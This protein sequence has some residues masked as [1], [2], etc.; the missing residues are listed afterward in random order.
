MALKAL[1]FSLRPAYAAALPLEWT[2]QSCRRHQST[3]RRTRKALRVKPDSSFL[4]TTTEPTDHV[5]FNP[6]SSAPN[7]YHTPMKFL[8]KDDPRQK[9]HTLATATRPPSSIVPTPSSDSPTKTR[10][11]PSVR[12]I[13]QKKYHLT[14][15]E[16]DEIR[17]LREEDP[18]HWTRVRLGEKF[19]CSEFF[20]SLCCKSPEIAAEREKEIEQ[21][22]SRWGRS[23][24][25]AREERVERRKLWGRDA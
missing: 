7:I 12:P 16:I 10:L 1:N 3:F 8:P 23:K 25:E 5:I 14:Q 11:I 19:N 15:V 17:R 9:L 18:R 13:Y 21:I 20:I 4:P 6:P 2:C 24:R 22:K